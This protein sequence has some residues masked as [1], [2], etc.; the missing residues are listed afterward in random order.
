MGSPAAEFVMLRSPSDEVG[1]FTLGLE[2]VRI[3]SKRHVSK[4]YHGVAPVADDQDA[5]VVL[6]VWVCEMI[7]DHSRERIGPRIDRL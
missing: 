1:Q 2:T 6:I 7:L 4:R 3:L 5:L